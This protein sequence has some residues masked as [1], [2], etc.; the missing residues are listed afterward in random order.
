MP[1]SLYQLRQN[2]L[3][4]NQWIQNLCNNLYRFVWIAFILIY[5]AFQSTQK[6]LSLY[7]PVFWVDR[8]KL[9]NLSNSC[10][11]LTVCCTVQGIEI[12]DHPASKL[13]SILLTPITI[14]DSVLI[15]LMVTSGKTCDSKLQYVQ[16][17]G[18]CVAR[19]Y[20]NFL[21]SSCGVV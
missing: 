10:F 16:M 9:V 7:F 14:V 4:W 5:Y 15:P 12:S 1:L 2:T 11:L 21:F 17:I 18:N 20:W 8:V 6:V 19:F 3:L 13:K